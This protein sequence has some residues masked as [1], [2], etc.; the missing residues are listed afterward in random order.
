MTETS[1][2]GMETVGR[3]LKSVSNDEYWAISEIIEDGVVRMR[4]VSRADGTPLPGI[5]S[6]AAK[7]VQDGSGYAHAFKTKDGKWVFAY[8]WPDRRNNQ[9]ASA[10]F[11]PNVE[12]A[13]E[14]RTK[15]G[16][17]EDT[18]NLLRRWIPELSV[19]SA[20]RLT[21]KPRFATRPEKIENA[22]EFLEWLIQ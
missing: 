10:R 17:D 19:E 18:V 14:R 21:K 1:N 7:R 12:K 16:R 20:E 9:P 11:A 22:D 6:W 2:V 13:I 15:R 8:I 3:I 5:K 4:R